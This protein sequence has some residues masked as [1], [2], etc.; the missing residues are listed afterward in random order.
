MSYVITFQAI[1]TRILA[2]GW[3]LFGLC[4]LLSFAVSFQGFLR[5]D[6]S[7]PAYKFTDL[8][9]LM[10]NEDFVFRAVAGGSTASF[11][12]GS[13]NPMHQEI[14]RRI[15]ENL[16]E[17]LLDKYQTAMPDILS[18]RGGMGV[19]IEEKSAEAYTAKNCDL[20]TVGNLHERSYG[21][22]F[23]RGETDTRL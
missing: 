6:Q 11:L 23:K 4:V 10:A 9:A 16:E 20:Y 19:V 13:Q 12:K 3:W 14:Y 5:A 8:N 17:N 15:E 1:S 22:A 7:I 21:L 18:S 2:A